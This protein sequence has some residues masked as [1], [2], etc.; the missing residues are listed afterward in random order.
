MQSPLWW[1]LLVPGAGLV[2]V[3][4]GWNGVLWG[5]LFVLLVNAAIAATLL[6][7]DDVSGLTRVACW[8]AAA[9]VYCV[10]Q[11]HF[12]VAARRARA[13]QTASQRREVL[14]EVRRLL[15]EGRAEEALAA[16]GALHAER[17][18]DLLVA[19]LVAQIH[20]L[21]GVREEAIQAWR[22]LRRLDRHRVY[23]EQVD[24]ALSELTAASPRR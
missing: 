4:A 8:L 14:S 13:Q 18:R 12:L 6:F 10:A 15:A 1:N 17:T 3:G 7:P 11:A 22:D 21:R 19:Y 2:L 20:T 24:A 9:G 16:M 23:R 5:L